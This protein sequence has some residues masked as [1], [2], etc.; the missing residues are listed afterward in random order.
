MLSD[1]SDDLDGFFNLANR[2]R[3]SMS[4][5]TGEALSLTSSFPKQIDNGARAGVQNVAIIDLADSQEQLREEYGLKTVV[6]FEA[7]PRKATDS[8]VPTDASVRARDD[9]AE[10]DACIVNSPSGPQGHDDTAEVLPVSKFFNP[11]KRRS[12][13][14]SRQ[15]EASNRA[16]PPSPR[17]SQTPKHAPS[18][19][20]SS[21]RK[22]SSARQHRSSSTSISSCARIL[23]VATDSE[24]DEDEN[25]V[26]AT[27]A[28]APVATH[29]P[30][31]EDPQLNGFVHIGIGAAGQDDDDNYDNDFFGE[32]AFNDPWGNSHDQSSITADPQ[33]QTGQSS[34]T[35]DTAPV[36]PQS[37]PVQKSADRLVSCP[38]CDQKVRRL[39]RG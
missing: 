28:P 21:S 10:V 8:A 13:C 38:I 22:F 1:G 33:R 12:Q 17:L 14:A 34:N 19:R 16:T 9:S 30:A 27:V 32:G 36:L 3:F 25:N 29:V 5:S 11:G 26:H 23:A 7:E 35:L 2:R 18:S 6:S 37:G 24:P 31:I 4:H 15:S 20:S 39:C